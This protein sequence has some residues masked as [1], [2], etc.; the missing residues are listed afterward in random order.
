VPSI[1]PVVVI[2][3]SSASLV[4]IAKRRR[5]LAGRAREPEV[6]HPH[7]TVAPTS[8]F[9]GLKSRWTSPD[10]VRRRQPATRLQI[11][12]RAAR[13]TR[14]PPP[15]PLRQRQALDELHRHEHLASRPPTS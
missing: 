1:A 4:G 3:C 7:P 9:S 13:A 12:L 11:H 6:D 10:R 15:L 8:T 2:G 5:R 14:A